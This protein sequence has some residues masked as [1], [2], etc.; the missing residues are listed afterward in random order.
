M[1]KDHLYTWDNNKNAKFP[2]QITATQFN[3]N[4]TSASTAT[5]ATQDGNG[6]VISSTYLKLSGGTMTGQLKT[7]GADIVLGATGTGNSPNDSGDLV[8]Q[9]GNGTEKMRIWSS[10]SYTVKHGPNFRV[11]N[12]NNEQL[13]TGTLPLADGTDATGTWGISITGNAATATTATTATNA[14]TALNV[15]A[16]A[17]TTNSARHVWF[18]DNSTETKRAY[19]DDFKYNPSTNILT[20]AKLSGNTV[21]VNN[22][23]TTDSGG[24]SLYGGSDALNYGIAMR[25]TSG[26]TKHGYTQGDWATY[27]SMVGASLENSKTR[28]WIFRNGS[29]SATYQ[30]VASISG[31]GH[32]VFNGSVTVGGNYENTS[33]MRMEYDATLQCTN[34]VFN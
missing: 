23:G 26:Q 8:Q 34:F 4:A 32:A 20:V 28:G 6:A 1:A 5:K 29:E 19:D 17:G 11:Y 30:N 9:Y 25:T 2:G 14:T 33:G 13:Y 15:S 7:N 27:F 10:D 12:E 18:S 21:Y 3:G 22:P 31:V 24:L 16:T